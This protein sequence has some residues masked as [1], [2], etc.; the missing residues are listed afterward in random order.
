MGSTA[1]ANVHITLTSFANESRLRKEAITLR[2]NIFKSVIIFALYADGLKENQVIADGVQVQRLRLVSRDLPRHAAFQILKYVEFTLRIL[3]AVSRLKVACINVH[4]LSLLPIG[5]SI[6]LIKNSRL[7]YDAH[8]LESEIVAG[9]GLKK[10][11]A[12]KSESFFVTKCDLI[13]VVSES[14]ADWYVNEYKILRPTVVLNAPPFRELVRKNYYRE[15]LGIREDQ[16]IVLYQGGLSQG[17]GISFLLQ[18]F[19][20][21]LSDNSVVMVFM[22]Y[23]ELEITIRQH[24]EKYPNIFYFPAVDPGVLLDFTSSA[25]IGV[26][27]IEETCLSYYFCM[28][29]K[30]FE[31]AMAGLPVVVTAM[32]EM[33]DFVTRNEM[34]MVLHD[35]TTVNFN[36]SIDV[37]L[38]SDLAAIGQNSYKAA[39]DNAWEVQEA[40]MLESYQKLS[41][42]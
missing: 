21:R 1:G 40:K 32:K 18:A 27:L 6:K 20:E 35:C 34:G 36:S 37:L 42:S 5:W 10:R 9:N 7:V 19:K 11:L 39:V 25:D 24:A 13:I 4:A 17:R 33:G 26:S 22:G 41:F 31:Y 38:A 30:L 23:G 2:N 12:R 3:L 15:L 29:N 8:E 28:P 14:I 16:K